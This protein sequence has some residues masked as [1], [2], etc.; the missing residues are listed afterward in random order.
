MGWDF[1]RTGKRVTRLFRVSDTF[2]LWD[3][4]RLRDYA[5]PASTMF[6]Q[7][8]PKFIVSDWLHAALSLTADPDQPGSYCDASALKANSSNATFAAASAVCCPGPS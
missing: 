5:T 1:H 2:W 8:D 4:C 6:H 3:G 7:I